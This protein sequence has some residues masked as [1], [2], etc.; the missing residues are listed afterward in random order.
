MTEKIRERD[1][2]IIFCSPNTPKSPGVQREL[3][4]VSA[5]QKASIVPVFKDIN[6]VNATLNRSDL[7]GVKFQ[8][9]KFKGFLEELYRAV[10]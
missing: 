5:F 8:E 9:K 4:M 6:D 3:G 2:I 7:R 10:L 1:I